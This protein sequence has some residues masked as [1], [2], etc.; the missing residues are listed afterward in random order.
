MKSFYWYFR[1]IAIGFKILGVFPLDN[2]FSLDTSKLMF[3]FTSA[4]HFY[5]FFIFT[6]FLIMIYLFSGLILS[7]ESSADVVQGYVIYGM[8]ARSIACF[9]MYGLRNFYELPKLIQLLDSYHKNKRSMIEKNVSHWKIIVKWTIM[10]ALIILV[11]MLLSLKLSAAVITA[12]LPKIFFKIYGR[13]YCYIFA[14]L[15]SREFYSSLLYIY[16][17]HAINYGYKEINETLRERNIL[18]S[19][20]AHIK[21]PSDMQIVLSNIRTLHNILSESVSQMSKVLG[22]FMALDQIGV[23]IVLVINISV[24]I[25]WHAQLPYLFS[26][27]IMNCV[28]VTWI[29][30]ISHEVTKN[31][32]TLS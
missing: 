4:S 21:Y 15:M 29:L 2:I 3:R 12:A 9:F 8:I 5:C 20:Y 23:I 13:A 10:P 25:N 17:A 24:F 16:F 30:L 1:P 32:S 22:P 26:L 28:L 11:F 7:S 27:T 14:Y 31:V 18:P 6:S 19:Y